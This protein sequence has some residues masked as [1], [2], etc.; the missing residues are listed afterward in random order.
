MERDNAK[1]ECGRK[2]ENIGAEGKRRLKLKEFKVGSEVVSQNEVVSQKCLV[3][4]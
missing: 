4:A 1:G 3:R 2:E